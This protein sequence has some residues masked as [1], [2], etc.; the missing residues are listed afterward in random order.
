MIM[1]RRLLL[2]PALCLALAG[3]AAAELEVK[4]TIEG[5]SNKL[6]KE[7]RPVSSLARDPDSFSALAPVRRAANSDAD[8]LLAA[9]QSKGFYAA[10]I[11]PEVRREEDN[12]LVTFTIETG[13]KFD[14]TGYELTYAD[15]QKVER[16]ES[17]YAMG[18]E[19]DGSPTGESLLAIENQI[20]EWF[21]NEGYLGAEIARRAVL[22]DFSEASGRATYEVR[23]GAKATYANIEVTGA[24]RTDVEY[25]RQYRTFERGD[26]AERSEID[27]YRERLVETALFSEVEVTPQLPAEDG[28]T[29]I[30]VRVTERKPRTIGGGVSYATDIGPT[31]TVFWE[32]RNAL[33]RGETLRAE[34]LASQPIQQ[35]SASFRK[36][37][38]RLPGFYNLQ[39]ILRNEDTDAFEAQTAQVGGS[40]G[41][42]WLN[43]DLTTEGG[44]LL[45]H[46]DIRELECF[47]PNGARI[48]PDDDESCVEDLG[49]TVETSTRIFQAVS[50]PLTV[51]WDNQEEP[52]DPQDGFR[53]RF[54]VQPFVGTVNFNRLETSYTDRIF[55]GEDDG[56]T[57][58]GRIR[59]G[60]IYGA[61]RAEIPATERYFA[62]GGGSIRGYAFQE[63]SPIDNTTGEILGGASLAEISVELRQHVTEA[64]EL[65]V[66]SDIGGAFESNSPD[67]GNVL[68]GAGIGVRYHTPIGPIRLDIAFPLDKRDEPVEGGPFEGDAPVQV[69]IGLGQ[70]F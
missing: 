21:W 2:A 66:F 41:K 40:I 57:L 20:L 68:V 62:G 3:Q 37:R 25:I 5:L 23:T 26:L 18:I 35:G 11:E 51:L 16:P 60:A 43:D 46:S 36:D 61:S 15:E 64:I 24:E 48:F 32:N 4:V 67:F 19:P 52:L 53:A 33:K 22:S 30:L 7:L 69:L 14:I 8:A 34:I 31:A 70:P 56:G 28:T 47:G 17:L 50:F 55:W 59:V 10:R 29:D 39:A 12:V 45:Q 6:R 13:T 42:F 38:P 58:A 27:R 9:L 63:A 44:I 65:A 49:G 54:T 1:L